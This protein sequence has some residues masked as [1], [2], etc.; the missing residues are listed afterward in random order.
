MFIYIIHLMPMTTAI[1]TSHAIAISTFRPD[2]P[3][4]DRCD[5]FVDAVVAVDPEPTPGPF[6]TVGTSPDES[7]AP[8]PVIEANGTVLVPITMSEGPRDIVVPETV[9]AVLPWNTSVPAMARPLG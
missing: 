3:L 2:S 9:M 6:V 8:S 7:A 4:A 1:I 5:S